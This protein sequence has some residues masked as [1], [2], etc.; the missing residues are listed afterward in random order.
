ML[1]LSKDVLFL[2]CCWKKVV[3]HVIFH[4]TGVLKFLHHMEP[5]IGSETTPLKPW[6]EKT[7]AIR[8]KLAK[9]EQEAFFFQL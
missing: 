8:P 6:Q 4:N 2:T 9:I 5:S 7:N 1:E 3:N